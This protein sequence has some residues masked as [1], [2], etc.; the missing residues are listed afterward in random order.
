MWGFPMLPGKHGTFEIDVRGSRSI[1][2]SR[3]VGKPTDIT[4]PA[5]LAC[6][7]LSQNPSRGPTM[8]TLFD[9]QWPRRLNPD[10]TYDSICPT[11]FQTVARCK[12]EAELA[13]AENLHVCP[14]APMLPPYRP[15]QEL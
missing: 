14:G 9:C 10:G 1:L 7:S 13:R 15:W 2:F 5:D 12:N 3:N 6:G 4:N 11:C 8:L